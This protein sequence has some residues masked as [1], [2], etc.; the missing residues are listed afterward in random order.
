MNKEWD[1]TPLYEGIET[2]K[3]RNDLKALSE[4]VEALNAFAAE[5]PEENRG[6]VLHQALELQEKIV[7]LAMPLFEYASL[8]SSTNTSDQEAVNAG[9]KLQKLM[10]ETSAA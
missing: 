4:Q 3:F 10:S 2:E 5:L 1:L 6:A 7:T 9:A 8:R